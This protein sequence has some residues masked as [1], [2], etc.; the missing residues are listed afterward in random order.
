MAVGAFAF[1]EPVWKEPLVVL[2]VGQNDFLAEDVSVLV[3]SP[4]EFLDEALVNRALCPS[5][6]VE[7]YLEGFQVLDEDLVVTVCKL[8][9]RDASLDRFNLNGCSVLIAPADEDNLF[10]LQAEVSRIDIR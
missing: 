2:A 10:A 6:V 8:A 7:F 4:V 9:G 5:V 1:D 3:Y